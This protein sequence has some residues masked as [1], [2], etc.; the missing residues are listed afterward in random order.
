[1]RR[2]NSQSSTP[3]TRT[4]L[5]PSRICG[6]ERR[7]VRDLGVVLRSHS[8]GRPGFP[9]KGPKSHF[10]LFR[11]PKVNASSSRSSK[12]LQKRMLERAR[13]AEAP[14]RARFV[15]TLFQRIGFVRSSLA[16]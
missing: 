8:S 7:V 14:R 16:G 6:R 10:E 11:T 4:V 9:R 15:I 1:M 2:T 3:K 13:Y 12:V 5:F